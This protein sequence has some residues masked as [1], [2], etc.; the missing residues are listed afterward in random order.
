MKKMIFIGS[1]TNYLGE[2]N[3]PKNSEVDAEWIELPF[4]GCPHGG[5]LVKGYEYDLYNNEQWFYEKELA[6]PQTS[7]SFKEIA[8]KGLEH[9]EKERSPHRKTVIDPAKE[10][11]FSLDED[12]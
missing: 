4:I 7:T 9:V 10:R 6:E 3:P 1:I 5:W 2:N 11:I 8:K 12:F